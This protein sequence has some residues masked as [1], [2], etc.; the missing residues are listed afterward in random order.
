MRILK[1]RKIAREVVATKEATAIRVETE[2][3]TGDMSMTKALER[4]ACETAEDVLSQ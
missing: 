4:Q 3:K 2:R 1:V